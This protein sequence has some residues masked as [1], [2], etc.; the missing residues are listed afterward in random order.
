MTCACA[1]FGI[2]LLLFS[3]SRHIEFCEARELCLHIAVPCPH[4]EAFCLFYCSTFRT[5]RK[6]HVFFHTYYGYEQ[7]RTKA[8]N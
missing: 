2:T 8:K 7:E 5:W 6:D 3:S 4:F 1:T